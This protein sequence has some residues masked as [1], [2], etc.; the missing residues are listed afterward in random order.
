M[1]KV[2]T[3]YNMT[4][5]WCFYCWLWPESVYQYSVST[6][7]FEQAFVSRVW[8]TS[9]NVLKTQKAIYLLY[10]KTKTSELIIINILKF[11]GFS[12][13]NDEKFRNFNIFIII[14]SIVLTFLFDM[15]N[16]NLFNL[17]RYICFVIKFAGSISFSDLSLHQIEISYEQMTILWTYCGTVGSF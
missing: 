3:K 16:T 10:R 2:K 1:F 9:H 17:L 8:K 6:F 11:R 14:N 7:N 12:W 13:Q 4:S 5:F 15:T